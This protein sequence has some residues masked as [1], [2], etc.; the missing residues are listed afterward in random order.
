LSAAE[1]EWRQYELWREGV[2]CALNG[3]L[4]LHRFALRGEPWAHLVSAD[5]SA[6]L[7]AGELLGMRE[8]WLQFRPLKD[9]ASGESVPAWH[10]DLSGE[11]LSRALALAGP[12]VRAQRPR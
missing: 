8:A 10:W 3:G 9:P 11:R 5:R 4:W 12:I 7:Q 2:A 6:L 1:V